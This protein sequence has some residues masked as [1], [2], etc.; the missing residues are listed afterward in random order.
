MSI[1]AGLVTKLAATTAIT[2]ITSTRIYPEV[3]P[4]D[5]TVPALTYQRVAG[6]EVA[7]MDG[8]TGLART[9]IQINCIAATYIEAKALRDAVRTALAGTSGTWGSTTVQAC[10]GDGERDLP[11][12]AIGTDANRRRVVS[13][14][15]EIW[16]DE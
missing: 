12:L 7:S 1:E 9:T 16:Y 14:D 6:Y 15:F 10:Y 8:V 2:D 4:Q 3:L 5:G 11:D 13:M